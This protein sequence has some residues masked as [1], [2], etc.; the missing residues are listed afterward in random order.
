MIIKKMPQ[1][2]DD[3]DTDKKGG[4]FSKN[5]KFSREKSF[6][7]SEAD[8][9]RNDAKLNALNK[10]RSKERKQNL[11]VANG[12]KEGHEELVSIVPKF[13]RQYYLKMN[14][15]V[16]DVPADYDIDKLCTKFERFGAIQYVSKDLNANGSYN[17]ILVPDE[18]N[19]LIRPLQQDIFDKGSAEYNIKGKLALVC[20]IT[21][22][23]TQDFEEYGEAIDYLDE[24]SDST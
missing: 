1:R 19:E 4:K 9:E 20:S 22:D 18:W 2:N 14:L 21:R 17:A 23:S 12:T 15:V 13:E 10:E 16:N 3:K 24:D 8:I 7:Y 5:V 6:A 11:K